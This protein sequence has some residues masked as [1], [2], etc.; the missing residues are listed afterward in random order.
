MIDDSLANL[1]ARIACLC[2]KQVS[3]DS[4]PHK[5]VSNILSCP[6]FVLDGCKELLLNIVYYCIV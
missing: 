6:L 3:T 2:S 4:S 5:T 1:H